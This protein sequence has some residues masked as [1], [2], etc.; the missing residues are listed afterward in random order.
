MGSCS[1]VGLLG[2]TLGGGLGPYGGLHGLQLDALESVHMI[3][4]KG[5]ILDVSATSHS[6]LFWG[7]RGAGF[8]FGI[9]TSAVF[10]VFDFTNRGVATNAEFV[11]ASN[12]SLPVW[13]FMKKYQD[14]QP[15]NLAMD[16]GI[17][18][19]PAFGGVGFL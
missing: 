7:M 15:S 5:E 16:V 2:A 17:G 14:S 12:N 9:V 10:K 6:E 3:T 1:C 4:G 18:Y 19:N 8:N 11:F 13:N